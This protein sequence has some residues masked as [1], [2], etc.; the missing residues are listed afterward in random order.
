MK[1]KV[2]V[3]YDGLTDKNRDRLAQFREED[4]VDRLLDLP[5]H[6]TTRLARPRMP[7]ATRR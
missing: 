3:K 7:D 5:Q 2:A 4:N 1:A 6:L